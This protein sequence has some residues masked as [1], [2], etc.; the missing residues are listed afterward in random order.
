MVVGSHPDG[1]LLGKG[2]VMGQHVLVSNHG[3]EFQIRILLRRMPVGFL[4]VIRA[5]STL[6]G[7]GSAT[8]LVQ[9]V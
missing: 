8:G 6:Q 5:S 2:C 4:N 3:G 9:R 7:K 1:A